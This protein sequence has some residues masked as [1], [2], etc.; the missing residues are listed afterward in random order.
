MAVDIG[1]RIGIDGEA[2]YR[3]QL[4][5]IIQQSRTL[6]SEMRAVTSAFD[7][8]DRSQEALAAQTEVLNRQI[9]NQR[10]R[11]EQLQYGLNRASDMYGEADSRT[12]RWQQAV[13]NATAEMN[14]MERQ[15]D[16]LNNP[17]RNLSENTDDAGSNI[18]A[19]TVAIGNL[20]ADAVKSAI[21][22]IGDLVSEIWNLDEA[23]EEYRK[24]QGRLNT[25]YEAAGYGAETAQE[26]YTEFY[27]ILGDTDTAT[28][29]SQLLAQL[30]ENEQD[31]TE[32]TRIAAGV[33]GTFGDSLP[34]EGLIEAA[35]ETAR[36]GQVTGVLADALNWGALSGETF[37]VAMR[38]NTEANEEWNKSV[39]EAASAEDYFNLALQECSTES[40]RNQLIMDALA[41]GYEDAS[42]SF[43][44][45]NES[46]VQAR[47]SQAMMDETLSDLGATISDVKNRIQSEFTPAISELVGSFDSLLQGDAGAGGQF[48]G[49]I[50]NLVET[51]IQQAPAMLSAG[52]Q[53]VTSLVSGI[54]QSLPYLQQT[55][56][57]MFSNLIL[58]LQQNLPQMISVG[59]QTLLSFSGSLRENAGQLVDS[60]LTLIKTLVGGLI[61]SLPELISTVPTIVSNIAGIINDNAP[62]L[63]VTAG[64]LIWQLVTGL[65]ENIPVI[66]ENMPKIVQ[67]IVDVIM[68]FD[69][70]NLGSR[71][72]TFF[73]DGIKSMATAVSQAVKNVLQNPINYLKNLVNTFKTF[74]RNLMQFFGSGISGMASSIF[75]AVKGVLASAISYIKDLP[76]QALQWGKDFI[77]GLAGGIVSA[78]KG[79]LD[80]VKNIAGDI[81]S[82][83]HFSRPDRGPLRDYE[84]WMPDMIDGMVAG[85]E[86]NAHRLQNAVAGMA[87]GMTLNTAGAIGQ[88]GG[89]NQFSIVVNPAPGMNEERLANLVMQKMEH[90]VRQR[91]G[92][93]A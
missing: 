92:V 60:A 65:L 1:P 39:Q 55:A 74:G 34:I 57:T 30:A 84:S 56:S 24:A 67:A 21:S 29:A 5:N 50:Q 49:A 16:D 72:I 27:K 69:W 86:A 80:S 52:A 53:I 20:A 2:E 15:L 44:D 51:A 45:N 64:Q 66:V 46:L 89:G 17:M 90:M 28:E 71:I 22:A 26:A 13:N 11:L 75:N 58:Y 61:Q 8:G 85:I 93:W 31:V 25:A 62:K 38:E 9:E 87:G 12:Q 10:Q 19:M 73:K 70:L 3:R 18:S 40:E 37:G 6:A 41:K 43:Y 68:A 32:W 54:I 78:A 35:N 81:A 82:Y 88:A 47:E 79:L 7:D 77:G 63:L 23:T 36:V 59:L 42:K 48:A 4:N 83:M 33:S 76:K 14:R 91:E